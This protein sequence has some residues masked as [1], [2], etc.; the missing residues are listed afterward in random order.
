MKFFIKDTPKWDILATE[1]EIEITDYTYTCSILKEIMIDTHYQYVS[2]V[3]VFK[4]KIN[5][6]FKK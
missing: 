6:R 4:K 3:D 2:T 5:S 1:K